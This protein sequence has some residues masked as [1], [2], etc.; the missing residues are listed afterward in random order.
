MTHSVDLKDLQEHLPEYLK[1]VKGGDT[2]DVRNEQ[3][4]IARIVPPE[5]PAGLT[6]AH[7]A[8]PGLRLQDFRRPANMPKLDFDIVETLREDRD[9]R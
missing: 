9:A 2:I 5:R 6:W 7:R 1:K 8:T 3:Q 4:T